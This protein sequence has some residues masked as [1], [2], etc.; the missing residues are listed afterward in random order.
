MT[1]FWKRLKCALFHHGDK[2]WT[3]GYHYWD[4]RCRKCGMEGTVD[5]Y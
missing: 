2:V 3:P 1:Q 5:D 4:F